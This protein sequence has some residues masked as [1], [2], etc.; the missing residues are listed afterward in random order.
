MWRKVGTVGKES[1]HTK[2]DK[3]RSAFEFFSNGAASIRRFNASGQRPVRRLVRTTFEGELLALTP[4][5]IA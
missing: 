1:V 3:S 5:G 2:R 4:G